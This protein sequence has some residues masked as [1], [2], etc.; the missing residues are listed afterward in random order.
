MPLFCRPNYY[1]G[2]GNCGFRDVR[3]LV[4][5]HQA[6]LCRILFHSPVRCRDRCFDLDCEHTVRAK[7]KEEKKCTH[8]NTHTLTQNPNPLLSY[9]EVYACTFPKQSGRELIFGGNENSSK[10]KLK[11]GGGQSIKA[12]FCFSARSVLLALY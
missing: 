5:L 9:G 12:P 7:K 11:G 2:T 10:G 1:I 4:P 8:T 6:L 3:H